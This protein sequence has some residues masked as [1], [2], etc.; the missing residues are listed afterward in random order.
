MN[1]IIGDVGEMNIPLNPVT[2][3]IKQRPYRINSRYKE[4]FKIELD[5]MLDAGITEPIE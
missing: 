3:P 2:K 5:K 4:K 1:G